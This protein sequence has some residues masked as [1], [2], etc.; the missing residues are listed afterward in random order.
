[1]STGKK[2]TLKVNNGRLFRQF[3]NGGAHLRIGG[4][5]RIGVALPWDDG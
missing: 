4:G 3:A 5:R 2:Q 1:M